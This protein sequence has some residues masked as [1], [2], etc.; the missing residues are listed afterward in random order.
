MALE[1]GEGRVISRGGLDQA[2]EGV[3]DACVAR[4]KR[5]LERLLDCF[6][7]RDSFQL[8]DARLASGSLVAIDGEI[9][10]V[11]AQGYMHH[12]LLEDRQYVIVKV[13]L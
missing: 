5:L 10:D 13:Y 8:K 11:G 12:E 3:R 9:F 6:A 2:P 1:R 7:H 4:L